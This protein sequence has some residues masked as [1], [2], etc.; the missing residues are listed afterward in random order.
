MAKKAVK[1]DELVVSGLE[2][3]QTAAKEMKTLYATLRS[4]Q[5]ECEDAYFMDWIDKPSGVKLTI[6]P[7]PHNKVRGA[8]RLLTS[9]APKFNVPAEKNNPDAIQKGELCEKAANAILAGSNAVQGIRVEKEEAHCGILYGE[10]HMRIISTRDMLDAAKLSK[11]NNADPNLAPLFDAQVKHAESMSKRTPYLLEPMN[12]MGCYARRSRAGLEAHF[13][14]VKM[15]VADVIASYGGDAAL[16]LADRKPYQQVE[17]N[18]FYDR[19]FNYVWVT[20]KEKDPIKAEAHGL[21]FIP[22]AYYSPEGSNIYDLPERANLPFLYPMLKSGVWQRQ[23][24]FLTVS[25]TNAAA[26]MNAQFILEQGS[27]EADVT[28][29]HQTI[30]GIVKVPSGSKFGPLAKEIINPALIQLYQMFDGLADESTIFDQTLGQPI[31]GNPTFSANALMNQAGRLPLSPI[32]EGMSALF[33]DAMGII[34]QWM[35]LEG[36][37]SINAQ[38]GDAIEVDPKT[39]PETLVFDCT[40][41]VDM[42]ADKLQQSQ[43]AVAIL[44]A[45]LASKDWIRTNVLNIGQSEAEQSKIWR[46][47]MGDQAAMA[48]F[49]PFIQ[50][51]V[52]NLGIQQ[53]MA[54]GAV[55]PPGGGATPPAQPA[56]NAGPT[57]PME[58]IPSGVQ[59]AQ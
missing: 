37:T 43:T 30:G 3:A 13:Q 32:Q 44:Q 9:T 17:V 10:M 27:E 8:T 23:S 7:D 46:E 12:P 40:I 58:P 49:Q 35:K 2:E 25:A 18:I 56:E 21:S 36:K 55:P 15:T 34:F 6:S 54:G 45:G 50:K 52:A 59:G 39:L 26:L 33:S 42:P 57:Q 19:A 4:F 16:I 31:E 11:T 48:V 38:A 28:V 24:M 22:I 5:K 53:P 29:E 41:D 20:G 51:L 14:Q 47:A 1:K